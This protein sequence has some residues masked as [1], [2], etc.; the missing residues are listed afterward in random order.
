MQVLAQGPNNHNDYR[1]KKHK[2]GDPIDAMHYL[3][4]Y[5]CS[6]GFFFFTKYIDI[7]QKLVNYHIFKF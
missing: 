5:I 3:E 2:N 6:T 4:V 7:L 1:D